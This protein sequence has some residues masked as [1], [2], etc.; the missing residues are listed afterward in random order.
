MYSLAIMLIMLFYSEIKNQLYCAGLVFTADI[1][2]RER[3]IFSF[4]VGF[5][6]LFLHKDTVW[7]TLSIDGMD[8]VRESC[9]HS[10]PS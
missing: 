6:Y 3:F 10:S 8:Y 5:L 7:Y 2:W 4:F 9:R 1:R